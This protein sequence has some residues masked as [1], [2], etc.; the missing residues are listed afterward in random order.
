MAFGCCSRLRPSLDLNFCSG[1]W[2]ATRGCVGLPSRNPVNIEQYE[3]NVHSRYREEGC[4]R[5]SN[6][7]RCAFSLL[8]SWSLPRRGPWA[9]QLAFACP[10]CSCANFNVASSVVG[11]A[12]GPEHR[13][14][15][16]THRLHWGRNAWHA[17]RVN[18]STVHLLHPIAPPPLP[19]RGRCPPTGPSFA[20]R[21]RRPVPR[22]DARQC[23]RWR[24]G[25]YPSRCLTWHPSP[26]PPPGR[27]SEAT[28][29]GRTA[30]S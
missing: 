11:E 4:A 25:L 28:S 3:P 21:R 12:P 15:H 9:T 24:G 6:A 13:A 8:L 18:A 22:T 20:R 16:R 23:H 14:A 29:V 1:G 5:L 2:Q 10:H 7:T 26:P 17:G 19:H 27:T 30:P